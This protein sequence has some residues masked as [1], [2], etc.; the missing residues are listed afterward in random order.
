MNRPPPLTRCA[1]VIASVL[2]CE[3]SLL[4]QACSVGTK[5]TA[6]LQ[7]KTPQATV[8]FDEVADWSFEAAHPAVIDQA[9]IAQALQGL[10]IIDQDSQH[11]SSADGSKPMRVFSDEDVEYLAPLLARALSQAQP[12][13]VV[14][15]RLS[16]SAGSGSEPTAGTVYI[17]D[18]EL[19]VT[20][21]AHHGTLSQTDAAFYGQSPAARHVRFV[22]ESASQ[23]RKADPTVA[24]GQR[25]L[26]TL[27]VDYTKLNKELGQPSEPLVMA[28]VTPD[29]SKAAEPKAA[30]PVPSADTKVMSRAEEEL[31]EAQRTISR[32]EA[33][34]DQ[35]RRD[36]ESMR[37][38]LEA[39]D[40]E[41]RQVK[42]KPAPIK[43]DKRPKAELAVR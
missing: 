35:L 4:S 26:H 16:S 29:E 8:Y 43:R 31:K 25:N 10:F 19:F 9:T 38:Q 30:E 37:Q 14:A 28:S 23:R 5:S 18:Q 34:I 2:L 21:T 15:F 24:L 11:S 39:K 7:P 20:L 32:K 33:K 41:L 17:K 6:G 1:Y 27:A 13:F 12:E 36:L 40:K 3:A 22:P 42:T